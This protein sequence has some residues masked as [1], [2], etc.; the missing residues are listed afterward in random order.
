[1]SVSSSGEQANS[2]NPDASSQEPPAVSVH[3]RYVAFSSVATNLVAGDS[4][5][6]RDVFLRDRKTGTTRR[7]SVSSQ[8]EQA[9]AVSFSP[10]ISANGRYIAFSSNATNLVK[11][12]TNAT[13]DVFVYDRTRETT[14][15]V[16]VRNDGG[17]ANRGGSEPAISADG[18]HVAFISRSTNLVSGDTR[19][20]QEIFV[21]DLDSKATELVTAATDGGEANSESTRPSISGDGRYVAF[22]SAADN[23][24]A[25]DP[26]GPSRNVFIRDRMTGTTRITAPYLS[27]VGTDY[28]W[29]AAGDWPSISADGRYVAYSANAEDAD[30]VLTGQV[31]LYDQVDD[32]TVRISQ[33]PA[34]KRGNDFSA[35]ASISADGSDVA[36]DSTATNLVAGDT[37]TEDVYRWD[38]LTGDIQ[39]ISVNTAGVAGDD[40]S[41]AAG[42]SGDGL[43]VGF[44]SWATKLVPGDT[45]G[46]LDIFVRNLG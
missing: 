43:H 22:G 46:V 31:Y 15:R 20:E 13:Q 34:G 12:D 3:G 10:S 5:G 36:F 25:N 6:V 29:I 17:Q 16:S 9:N 44:V 23:L 24:I 14:V 21:R 40:G 2:G 26:D 39:R 19:Y 32:T 42:I 7:I 38:R 8:G 28:V 45:N 18:Q 41:R 11:R 30:G 4:N 35:A 33:T 1:M 37:S 27:N